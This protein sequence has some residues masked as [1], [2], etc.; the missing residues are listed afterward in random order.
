ML[1]SSMRS[2]QQ[3]VL[4]HNLVAY[5][6]RW[7]DNP[8][9]RKPLTGRA[10]TSACAEAKTRWNVRWYNVPSNSVKKPART[11]RPLARSARYSLTASA[12]PRLKLGTGTA[13]NEVTSAAHHSLY[14]APKEN[15]LYSRQDLESKAEGGS[16]KS[17]IGNEELLAAF[18]HWAHFVDQLVGTNGN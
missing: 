15:E 1:P 11:I 9:T 17:D 2:L 18:G 3:I 16:R 5:S 6:E 4:E 7:M 13:V 12:H 8:T 14:P 10:L